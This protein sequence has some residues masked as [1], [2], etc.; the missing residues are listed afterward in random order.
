MDISHYLKQKSHGQSLE[1]T[2]RQRLDVVRWNSY[3]SYYYDVGLMGFRY[4]A[5][6]CGP[7]VASKMVDKWWTMDVGSEG[8]GPNFRNPGILSEISNFVC[9]EVIISLINTYTTFQPSCPALRGILPHATTLGALSS[10]LLH[11]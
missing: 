4:S 5:L 8:M 7:S 10:F 2:P 3:Q 1:P 11:I 6:L 9:G